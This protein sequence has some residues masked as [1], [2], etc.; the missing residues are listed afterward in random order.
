MHHTYTASTSLK[1]LVLL[2]ISTF[3]KHKLHPICTLS[4][5]QRTRKKHHALE[6]SGNTRDKHRP[7]FFHV[8]SNQCSKF[9]TLSPNTLF[10]S[11]VENEFTS[12][13]H[14]SSKLSKFTNM[15]ARAKSIIKH[16]HIYQ[17][18]SVHLRQRKGR[19]ETEWSW[20]SNLRS[21]RG[22]RNPSSEKASKW[23]HFQ[24]SLEAGKRRLTGW[25]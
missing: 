14:S 15:H 7:E 10:P 20:W 16:Y 11:K 12:P 17:W 25:D 22:T 19:H 24:P 18:R 6:V 21:W 2:V 1:F 13:S 9:A 5:L 4:I 8:N 3:L 23:G